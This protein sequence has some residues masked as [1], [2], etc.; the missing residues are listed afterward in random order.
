MPYYATKY[1]LTA[2]IF[3]LPDDQCEL[4]DG[5]KYL[6]FH[7]HGKGSMA[8]SLF[9]SRKEYFD[10]LPDAMADAKARILAKIKANEKAIAELKKILEADLKPVPFGKRW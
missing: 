8:G 9:L 5:G 7:A 6:S 4:V 3:E 2:G 1:A 10:N